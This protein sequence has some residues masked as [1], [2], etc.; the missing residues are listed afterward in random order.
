VNILKYIHLYFIKFLQVIGEQTAV[1]LR[2][3]ILAQVSR[4]GGGY[5]DSI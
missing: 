2:H 4:K 5:E 3:G 1:F